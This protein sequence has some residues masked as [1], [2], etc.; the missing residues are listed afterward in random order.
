MREQLS[1][2]PDNPCPENS[3]RAVYLRPTLKSAQNAQG[4]TAHLTFNLIR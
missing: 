2:A 3:Y 1:I 4:R